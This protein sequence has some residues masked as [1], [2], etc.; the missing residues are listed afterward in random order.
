M[1]RQCFSRE[2][3][4]GSVDGNAFTALSIP[5]WPSVGYFEEQGIGSFGSTTISTEQVGEHCFSL[6]DTGGVGVSNETPYPN[7]WRYCVNG[8]AEVSTT[9]SSDALDTRT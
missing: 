5:N 6:Q 8:E 1:S 3:L 2:G 4:V 7:E 9:S